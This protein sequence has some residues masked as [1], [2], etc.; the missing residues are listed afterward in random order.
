V[1]FIT[2]TSM[3]LESVA[4]MASV[5]SG[6][7]RHLLFIPFLSVGFGAQTVVLPCAHGMHEWACTSSVFYLPA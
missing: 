7:T 1:W 4:L 5:G 6:H 3:A 2:E